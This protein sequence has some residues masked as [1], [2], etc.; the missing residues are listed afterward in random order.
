MTIEHQDIADANR[1]EPRGADAA[2]SGHVL[3]SNGDTTTSFQDPN[4]L[5]DVGNL[6]YER[7]LTAFSTA[8]S[9]EPT[10]TDTPLQVEF[11]NAQGTV[12]D[13]V[14]I[15][16]LGNVTFNEA[17]SYIIR[18]VLQ[19]G[20]TGSASQAD[21]H[22]RGLINGVQNGNSVSA[23]VD[24][25]GVLIASAFT[26]NA[27][28]PTGA[29]FTYEIIRDSSGANAG[30]LFSSTPTVGWNIS[31]TASLVVDRIIAA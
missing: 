3:T 19:Y 5:V 7:V 18:V 12:S 31:P 11:G 29:I 2:T 10:G 13:P 30:G 22:A 1:H 21:L 9:Q 23:S 14:M 17:G 26:S 20:R 6:Q 25:A 24:T 8:T 28:V 27:N 16:N 4:T 15:D